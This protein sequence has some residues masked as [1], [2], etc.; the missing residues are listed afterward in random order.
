MDDYF[1]TTDVLL[2]TSDIQMGKYARIDGVGEHIVD[3]SSI[4]GTSNE[5]L[6]YTTSAKIT[7]RK[8]RLFKQR[9]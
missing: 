8:Y 9:V 5:E 7:I 1:N 3:D 6:L 2:H 4:V